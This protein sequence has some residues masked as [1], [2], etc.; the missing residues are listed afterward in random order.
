MINEELWW[1]FDFPFLLKMI[2]SN[3][4]DYG[5]DGFYEMYDAIQTWFK[6]NLGLIFN[7]I[8]KICQVLWIV[9]IL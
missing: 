2:W 9:L 4:D 8:M 3:H 7:V 1:S 5:K 6:I